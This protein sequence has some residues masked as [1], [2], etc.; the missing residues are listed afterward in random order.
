MK[1]IIRSIYHKLR[2]EIIFRSPK[3]SEFEKIHWSYKDKNFGDILNPIL[4]N[5]LTN[6]DAVPINA[7]YYKYPNYLM[8]GSILQ[9]ANKFSTIWGSGFISEKSICIEK[10]LKVCAVRGKLTRKKLLEQGIECPEVYGDPALLMP[11]VYVPKVEKK[12]KLGIIPHYIDKSHEWLQKINNNDVLVIDL[13]TDNPLSII[14]QINS[15]ESIASSSL[16]GLIIS[17]AYRIPS[18]W[19]EFS[20][21][22]IGGYFKFHD[23]F[24]SVGKKIKQ[25]YFITT[26]TSIEDLKNI[27]SFEELKIDL[28]LLVESCPFKIHERV[29]KSILQKAY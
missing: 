23:Y 19:I 3:Y 4:F 12:Y 17:D 28:K 14:D 16:H 1:Q 8:I 10:P 29:Y 27:T 6:K 11:Y 20:D 22:L 9:N 7:Q 21:K 2:S 24:S 13:I 15:C 26:K 5:L 18:V 25:P